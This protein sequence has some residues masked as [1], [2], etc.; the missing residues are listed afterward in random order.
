MASGCALMAL[1]A[2]SAQAQ[3]TDAA[4]S[5]RLGEILVT[6]QTDGYQT[7]ATNTAAKLPLTLR[8]TPQAVTVITRQRIEDFNLITVQDVLEQTPGV[9]VQS[10]DSNRTRFQARGF[11]ITNFQLD[12]VPS[13]FN[14]GASGNS[15]MPDT[16][17]FERIEVVRG[18][19][20]LVTGT[21]DPSATVN[22]VRKRPTQDLKAN[23][24]LNYGSWDYVRAE[25]DVGGPLIA[26]GKIR[27][28]A[29]AA[30]TSRDS[31][32]DFQHDTSPSLYGVVEADITETTRL[33]AGVDYLSTDSR[34][35]SWSAVPLFF[36]DGSR[37]DLPRSY[38]AAA[39]WNRWQRENTNAFAV[40][41]QEIGRW[42]ARLAY[43]HRWTD[44]E[45]LLLAGSNSNFFPDRETGLGLNVVNTYGIS[46]TREDSFDGYATGPLGLFG[47]EH[48]VV[49]GVNH[50]DRE[51]ENVAT[52]LTPA[53]GLP[54][55]TVN[56]VTYTA[57]PSIFTWDGDVP[58]PTTVDRGFPSS[59]DRTRQT[60][61]YGAVRLNPFDGL[62]VI[63]GGRYTD[64]DT[65]ARTFSTAAATA[66]ELTRTTKT[67]DNKFSPYAGVV[68]DLTSSVSAFASYAQVFTVQTQRDAN[69]E[70]LA[71]L[72]GTNYEF[73]F[74]GEFFDKRLY[75]AVSG[76]H[77]KQD[78][79]AELIQGA[80][81]FPDGTS[82]Y[83][84]VSGVKTWGAELEVAGSVT[85]DWRIAGGYTYVHS[86]NA[87]GSRFSP[88]TP[89]HLAKLN[90]TY[91]IGALTLGGGGTWQSR[92]YR[93]MPI[94][95]GA[96]Q[97][98]GQP[99]TATGTVSQGSYVLLDLLMRYDLSPNVSVGVNATN[100]LDKTYYRNVG[101]FNAGW[102][103]QLRRVLANL[104]WHF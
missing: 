82:P 78:N 84:A 2:A 6:G 5:D 48:E 96:F 35:G 1:A 65:T 12:G 30:Y 8:E 45:S 64:V 90:T 81:P 10:Y 3:T 70:Q 33:R 101:F 76:F 36:S 74:K 56:R 27:A 58:R 43:N 28:R 87:D 29:V 100:V 22:L 21:G 38:S 75:A 68:W 80:D 53:Y 71:P 49:L 72:T 92:I 89:Q 23:V 102:Y 63:L 99:V 66:G 61:L 40:L 17:I 31:Y 39:R 59:T 97:S 103:G 86:E 94:P 37:T 7:G 51:L 73:G 34:G 52:T 15:V 11:T 85:P 62:K 77:M 18:A 57:F 13:N 46:H 14:V 104:R 79:V 83:R 9:S 20:G 24:S 44:T 88:D 26:S 32:L 91:K 16:S 67:G 55:F 93:S 4:Q 95:T 50:Y 25:A 41:E 60:S 42:V 69:Y 98:N 19:A 47:R 54:S